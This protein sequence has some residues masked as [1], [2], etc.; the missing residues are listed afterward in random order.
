MIITWSTIYTKATG[1]TDKQGKGGMIG[2]LTSKRK[3]GSIA[4]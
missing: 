1:N 2:N 4:D 3:G